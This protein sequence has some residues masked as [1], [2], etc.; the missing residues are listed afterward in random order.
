MKARTNSLEFVEGVI[1]GANKAHFLERINEELSF[2]IAFLKDE[3]AREHSINDEFRD[4]LNLRS[5]IDVQIA[6]Y[7]PIRVRET[8][9]SKIKRRQKESLIERDKKTLV[10]TEEDASKTTD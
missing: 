7:K 2:Q 8:L 10:G 4:K 5:R 3:L 9:S 6:D 1:L